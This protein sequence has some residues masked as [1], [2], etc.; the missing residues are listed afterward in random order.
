MKV[1]IIIKAILTVV[2]LVLLSCGGDGRKPLDKTSANLVLTQF[3]TQLAGIPTS[4]TTPTMATNISGISLGA[5]STQ[6]ASCQTAAPNPAVDAD[7]DGIA[8]T[9]T[10]KIDCKDEVSGGST[11]TQKGTI[12]FK[13][14]DD[15]VKGVYGG[16]RG[17]YDLPLFSTKGADGKEFNYSHVG[18]WEYKNDGGT[19]N[20]ISEYT[21]GIKYE[22]QGIKLNYKFT[23]KWKY[24]MIPDNAATPFDKGKMVIAGSFGMSGDFSIEDASGKP[25]A[26][27]GTWIISYTGVDLVYDR[28]CTNFYRSGSHVISDNLNKIEIVY[29]CTTSTLYVNGTASD[30]WRP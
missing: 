16:M 12:V 30:W 3:K 11:F 14:L 17:D 2:C 15:T 25:S 20:S 24:S 18:F 10:Y 6:A 21:G 9:K 28:T 13:D 23:Q 29:A 8:L 27:N 19:L 1:K 22:E 5:L 7:G 26:Y 4:N